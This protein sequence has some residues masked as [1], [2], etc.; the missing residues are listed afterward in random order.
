MLVSKSPKPENGD[1]GEQIPNLDSKPQTL[2]MM[3][4]SEC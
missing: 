1:V 2:M 3:L 4:V